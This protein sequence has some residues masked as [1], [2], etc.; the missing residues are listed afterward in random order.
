MPPPLHNIILFELDFDVKFPLLSL[1]Q[2]LSDFKITINISFLFREF[3]KEKEKAQSRGDFQRLRA[4]QQL[5][6]DLQVYNILKIEQ[7]GMTFDHAFSYYFP[8]FSSLL[9]KREE[10]K[11]NE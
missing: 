5:E 11:E 7:K 9:K 1:L 10:E 6:E 2:I 8:L 3:S 4:Q